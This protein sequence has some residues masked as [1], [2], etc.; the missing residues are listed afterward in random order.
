[1]DTVSPSVR[2][3]I[4]ASVGT[5]NTGPELLLRKAL[6][7]RGFRFRLHARHLPG[8]P[9]LILPRF[10]AAIFVHGCFWHGHGCPL[11]TNPSTRRR[12]WRDKFQANRLRDARQREQLLAAGWRVA[13]AWQCSLKAPRNAAHSAAAKIERWLAGRRRCLEIPASAPNRVPRPGKAAKAR[14]HNARRLK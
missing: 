5:S 14:R 3:R 8:S 2:S 4:M 12:F 11:S 7:R 13:T 6:H 9:D 10:K 1:M